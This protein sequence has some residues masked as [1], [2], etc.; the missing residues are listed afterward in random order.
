MYIPTYLSINATTYLCTYLPTYNVSFVH[1]STYLLTWP[2]ALEIRVLFF[3]LVT[4]MSRHDTFHY[5]FQYIRHDT[6]YISFTIRK[7]IPFILT[8]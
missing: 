6:C 5:Y 1:R 8:P 2:L 4:L 3:L 7:L